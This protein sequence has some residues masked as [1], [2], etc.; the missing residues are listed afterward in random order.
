MLRSN[1]LSY[2]A[3]V[4]RIFRVSLTAVN[5]RSSIN[6]RFIKWLGLAGNGTFD[7]SL[8]ALCHTSRTLGAMAGI[9]AC[10]PLSACS[11]CLIHFPTSPVMTPIQNIGLALFVLLSIGVAIGHRTECADGRVVETYLAKGLASQVLGH[12]LCEQSQQP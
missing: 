5:P 12:D 9:N 6:L 7:G 10:H 3:N 11:S 2:V 8:Q 4:A 1:R